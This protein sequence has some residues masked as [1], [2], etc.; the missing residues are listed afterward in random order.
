MTEKI[1]VDINGCIEIDITPKLKELLDKCFNTD[2]DD[3]D[4]ILEEIHKYIN[5][6]LYKKGCRN[7]E[8]LNWIVQKYQIKSIDRLHK[9]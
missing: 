2:D 5:K 4:E 7:I 8:I 6:E 1:R 3:D 9:I